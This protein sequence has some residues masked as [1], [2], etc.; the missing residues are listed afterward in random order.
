MNTVAKVAVTAMG[1]TAVPL[2]ALMTSGMDGDGVLQLVRA[3]RA[4]FAVAS[5]V[6]MAAL[7]YELWR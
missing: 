1:I 2:M 3:G 7:L 5:C 4:M 6:A